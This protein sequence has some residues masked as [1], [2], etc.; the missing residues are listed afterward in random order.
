MTTDP[1]KSQPEAQRPKRGRPPKPK[2][3]SRSDFPYLWEYMAYDLQSAKPEP[4]LEWAKH[5]SFWAGAFAEGYNA[6]LRAYIREVRAIEQP[7]I[8]K[9]Q[10]IEV[11]KA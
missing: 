8:P 2:V 6:C 5:Q 4:D 9:E 10:S 11:P 3:L 1:A 7:T